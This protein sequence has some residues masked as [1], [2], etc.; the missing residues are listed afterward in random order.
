MKE[1]RPAGNRKAI[2]FFCVG[3]DH[4]HVSRLAFDKVVELFQ[5]S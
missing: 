4:D 1:D 2:F 3:K 5:R